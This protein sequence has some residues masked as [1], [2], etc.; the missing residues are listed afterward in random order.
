MMKTIKITCE[1]ADAVEYDK[2]MDFQGELKEMNDEDAERLDNAIL[3][4]GFNSPVHVW[5]QGR[6]L[7]NLD[8]H[9]RLK[10]VRRFVEEEGYRCPPIPIDYIKAKNL[11]EAKHILLSRVKQNFRSSV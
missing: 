2:I 11:K 1:G 9:Q 7:W 6:K 5:K 3:K 10:R 8:G 4:Y